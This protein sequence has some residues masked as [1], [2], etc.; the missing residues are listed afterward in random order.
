MVERDMVIR[1]RP[2]LGLIA[3]IALVGLLGLS[4]ATPDPEGGNFM[5][6]T[7]GSELAGPDRKSTRLNSSHR[8]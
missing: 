5:R 1:L 2:A 4:A 6:K 8:L 3:A 7:G